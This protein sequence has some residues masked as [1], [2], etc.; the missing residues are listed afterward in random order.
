MRSLTLAVAALA[1]S[2]AATTSA[3]A[4][5]AA[6]AAPRPHKVTVGLPIHPRTTERLERLFW[7]ISTPGSKRYLEH[8]SLAELK[9]LLGATSDVEARARAW[10][11]QHGA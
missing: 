8:A 2:V 4:V 5:G 11:A 9:E 7:D 3:G 6:A 10:L 1:A